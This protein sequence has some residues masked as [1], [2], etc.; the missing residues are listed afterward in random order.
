MPTSTIT[1]KAQ[2]TIPKSVRERLNLKAGD[3][4]E[5]IVQDDGTALMIPATVRVAELE[6]I[7]P[8]P[9]KPVSITEMNRVIRQRGART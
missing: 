9:K 7:L 4:V 2:T 6:G 1:S 5:F 3:R 8:T